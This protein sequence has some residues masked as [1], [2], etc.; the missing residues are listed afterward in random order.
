[1][2]KYWVGVCLAVLTALAVSVTS[3]AADAATE[4]PSTAPETVSE[5]SDAQSGASDAQ[6]DTLDPQSGAS[7]IEGV[8]PTEAVTETGKLAYGPRLSMVSAYGIN[9]KLYTFLQAEGEHGPEQM[10]ASLKLA[11]NTLSDA[12]SAPKKLT[13]SDS[14]VRYLLMVDLSGSMKK[15]A[16]V[17]EP[18]INSLMANEKQQTIFT[19]AGFGEKFEQAHENLTD[20]EAVTAAVRELVYDEMFTDPYHGLVYALDYM[21][22][23][24]RLGGDLLNLVIITDGKPALDYTGEEKQEAENAAAEAALEAL[25]K[26]AGTVVHTVCVAEWD[27]LAQQTLSQGKGQDLMISDEESAVSAGME[28][29]AFVDGLYRVDFPCPKVAASES[30]SVQL[31]FTGQIDG[32]IAVSETTEFPGV[33][34]LRSGIAL[35]DFP[36]AGNEGETEGEEA[37]QEPSSAETAAETEDSQTAEETPQAAEDSETGTDSVKPGEESSEPVSQPEEE[38]DGLNLPLMIGITVAVILLAALVVLL[39]MKSR[40]K[41]TGSGT[42]QANGGIFIKL[43]VITGQYAGSAT[44]FQLKDQLLIGSGKQCDLIWRDPGV[45]PQ[46]TRVFLQDQVVYIEDLN[47]PGGTYLCGMRLYAPNRLRSGNDISIGDVSFRL[48]F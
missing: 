2:R 29:A 8:Q 19:V 30:F 44:T 10:K 3:A 48:R 20:P 7:V 31:R 18:F 17:I 5:T 35:S 47:S 32:N 28:M 39:V 6:G 27:E 43:E 21:N 36:S 40:K 34:V 23:S 16:S 46:N 24:P 4:A 14:I 13:E 45:A 9:D 38:T 15:Y 11:D 22:S 26:A 41:N 33:T 12:L 25:G 37:A 1:M 42:G